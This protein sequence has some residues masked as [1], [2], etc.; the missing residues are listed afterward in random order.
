MTVRFADSV[1]DAVVANLVAILAVPI[2]S[3][4]VSR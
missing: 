1:V 2:A 3:I 4:A